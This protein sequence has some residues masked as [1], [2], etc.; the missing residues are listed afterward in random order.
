MKKIKSRYL[1][2]TF[3]NKFQMFIILKVFYFI[4]IRETIDF[5]NYQIQNW[6]FCK[7]TAKSDS[8]N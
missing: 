2:D 8:L 5:Y 3:D 4:K 1:I 7:P 6:F